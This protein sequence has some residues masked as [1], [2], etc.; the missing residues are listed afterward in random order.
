MDTASLERWR[1]LREL[2]EAAQLE[3]LARRESFVRARAGEDRA[4][5]DEVLALLAQEGTLGDWLEPP[6]QFVEAARELRPRESARLGERVGA[7]RLERKIGVGG[8]GA[9]YLAVRAD[10]HFA[11]RAAVK[12]LRLGVD[13]PRLVERFRRE[14]QVLAQLEH[15]GV[16]RLLDGGVTDDG[17]PYIAMEY[18]EGAPIDRWC[19]EQRLSIRERL[20]LFLKV[21]AAVQYAHQHLVV[22]RDLKPGNIFVNAQGEPKLLDFG[23]AK[24]L[25]EDFDRTATQTGAH[26]LTPAYA[27][28]EQVRGEPVTTASDVYSLGVV[29][30]ELLT[31][32]RPHDVE[33]TS[34]HELVRRI[35]E[36]TPKPP[37]EAVDAIDPARAGSTQ[38]EL[39]RRRL[40]GDLDGIVLK[41][42]HKEPARRYASAGH[43]AE[44]IERH[45]AD[46]P[47]T[48]RGDSLLYRTRKLVQRHRALAVASM[49]GLTA[50]FG[51]LI[52]SSRL[53]WI[54]RERAEQ[55]TRLSDVHILLALGQDV[56]S[57]WPATRE[58]APN[59]ARWVR[60]AEALL[61]RRPLHEA[62]LAQLRAHGAEV[63]GEWKFTT[64]TEA[65]EHE[66]LSKLL[67]GLALLDGES[68][69]I[70]TVREMRTRQ[71]FAERVDE[72]TLDSPAAARAWLEA[73]DEIARLP[74][75]RGLELPPQRGL[76]PLGLNEVSGLWEFWHPQSGA[77]PLPDERGGFKVL[78]QS[79]LVLVLLP[80]GEFEMGSP[81]D[82]RGHSPEE[83]PVHRLTLDPFFASKFELTQGQ[84]AAITGANPAVLSR[85]RNEPRG[86]PATPAHPIENVNW[87]VGAAWLRRAHLAFPTE[88]QWEYLAR[89]GTRSA[90]WTGPERESLRGA[91]NLADRRAAA[92]G[93]DWL[94]ISDWPELDDGFAYHAP[95]GSYR[96]NAFGLYDVL[97]NVCEWCDDAF[98]DY[99]K[100]AQPGDGRRTTG[101]VLNRPLRGGGF[102]NKAAE[103]RCAKRVMMSPEIA[104]PQIGLR[105]IRAIER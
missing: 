51:G 40:R 57:Y 71:T 66:V 73:R 46:W 14:R 77:R 34:Y 88:A 105:P 36:Q 104:A 97:G 39:A 32:K 22:H 99:S 43:L 44:D 56:D 85:E 41:A 75:Y 92:H 103:L 3:P 45:L 63:A 62:R 21:C 15:P 23:L 38:P 81:P 65:W 67:G 16:A 1:R 9:V 2:L 78:E 50:L 95:V 47:V 58:Q 80:G 20:R 26:A 35:A 74:I 4:L 90:W 100:P 33:T 96:A 8:M 70:G 59:M 61:A 10:G 13:S 12:L 91:A 82:E 83:G 84:Y 27:S 25:D 69:T 76:L 42:L 98:G 48:A 55:I 93:Q 101:Y 18:V 28:P 72:L 87:D 64:A 68:R 31:G 54:A 17:L 19:D 60:Q 49:L 7:W 30:Y 86:A 53:W 102:S 24:V 11:Q 5:A 52:V 37:S 29:L 79:A 94:E 6:T 89:A